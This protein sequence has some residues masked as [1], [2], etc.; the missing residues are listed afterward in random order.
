MRSDR[1][2]SLT[3]GIILL[4]SIASAGRASWQPDQRL[5]NDDGRS[6]LSTGNAHCVAVDSSGRVHVVW[7]DDTPGNYEI[8]Y[9]V[10]DSASAWPPQPRRLTFNSGI[11][12]EPSIAV[13]PDTSIFVAWVDDSGRPAST[14]TFCRFYPRVPGTIDSGLVSIGTTPCSSPCV[15]VGGD[16]V[17]HVV[18]TQSTGQAADVIC[19]DWK[20][21]WLGDPLAL[22]SGVGTCVSATVAADSL[23]NAHVAWANNLLGNYEIYYRKFTPGV[24]WSN[25]FQV[26]TSG[27]LAWSP[28]IGADRNGNAYLVWSDKKDGNFEIY[29]RRYLDGIGWGNQKRLSYNPAVSGNPSVAV[30]GDGNLHMVWED[31][32]DGNDEIYY[33]EITNLEGPGWDPIETRLTVDGSTSWDPSVAA[34]RRGNVHVVWADNRDLNFEIYYKLG[35]RP[36]PVGMDLI[37]FTAESV[38]G[39]VMLN[40]QM[41]SFGGVAFFDVYREEE[42]GKTRTR[43]T[44]E[45]LFAENEFLDSNA[46]AGI[47]YLY[48]L[49]ILD[50]KEESLFGPVTVT[51]L[52]P[53]A[54]STERLA[55]WPNP[56]RGAIRVSF[57][58]ERADAP[59]RLSVVDVTGR[60]VG[61]IASGTT[62]GEAVNFPWN[63]VNTGGTALSPGVYFVSLEMPGDCIRKKVVLLR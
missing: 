24:G 44:N 55:V 53:P 13:L 3:L 15:A 9:A 6:G 33:R 36:V 47:T 34:D 19:R 25:T 46:R 14:V 35:I 5:T 32:R 58:P 23:G 54:P 4:G 45:S 11:S 1:F 62:S 22:T 10:I 26:S 49:G 60:T 29:F 27:I 63:P 51:Y 17:V 28:S 41:D 20:Q 18:W 2:L 12:R 57:A 56:S 16:S 40:W 38:P 52:P 50:G 39:G 43:I 42:G 30:D 8:E 31:F 61:V 48:F 59:F 37:D 21:G 7:H